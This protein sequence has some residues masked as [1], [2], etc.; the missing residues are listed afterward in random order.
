[1]KQIA[2][3]IV[4]VLFVWPCQGLARVNGPCVNCHT[5]HNSQAG[6][7]MAY[8]VS[9]T[10]GSHTAT[11]TPNQGLLITDCVGCHQGTNSS[12]SVPYILDVNGPIY[13]DSGT[14][15]GTTTLA[16]GNFY[17]VSSGQERKGHNV[18]GLSEIDSVLGLTPPGSPTPLSSQLTCSGTTGC[19]G[20]QAISNPTLA[21]YG[22]HHKND[23]TIWKNGTSVATSYRFLD[24][25][26][27][28]GD[29]DYEFQPLAGQ[30]NKYY[31]RNRLTETAN[32]EGT[33]SQHCATCHG[34]FHNGSG[35][36]AVGLLSS[37]VWLRHP[38]D[39]DMSAATS[40]SEYSAY[41][42]GSGTNNTYSVIAP[43]A[44]ESQSTTIQSTVFSETNDAVVMC[45][46]CHRAHGTP[47]DALLRW[48][49]KTWP[50]AGG[51]NGCAICHTAKD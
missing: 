33:I 21:I 29:S 17:W 45:L 11:S 35:N 3:I 46:S 13:G 47:H 5:M 51:Y 15:G 1:M 16:G 18:A 2:A 49:Y 38:T 42:M 39:F 28:L 22:G 20:D 6:V 31:G 19:H 30:H 24:G 14:E 36:I 48:D 12:G 41:N 9:L 43:L 37:G 23:Q 4:L 10:D 7:S 27:G 40:S 44:T 50:Q 26:Q 32:A 8:T 25:I 34:D